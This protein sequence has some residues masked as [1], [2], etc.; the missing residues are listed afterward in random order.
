MLMA[1]NVSVSA[2]ANDPPTEMIRPPW[3][4]GFSVVLE[5]ITTTEAGPCW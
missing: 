1:G 4:T 3:S 5:V 2:A